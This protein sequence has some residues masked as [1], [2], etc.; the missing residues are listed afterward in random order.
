MTGPL[1][2]KWMKFKEAI[3]QY[4]AK[5]YDEKPEISKVGEIFWLSTCLSFQQF[6]LTT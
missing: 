2:D 5:Y 6:S 1:K 4:L 3:T